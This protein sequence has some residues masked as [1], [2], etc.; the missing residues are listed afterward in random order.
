MH[1]RITCQVH[2]NIGGGGGLYFHKQIIHQGFLILHFLPLQRDLVDVMLAY[3][4]NA[5]SSTEGQMLVTL[6]HVA[7][8]LHTLVTTSISMLHLM[9]EHFTEEFK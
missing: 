2:D 4:R 6:Y 1:V 3:V 7:N 8:I 9:R 5:I